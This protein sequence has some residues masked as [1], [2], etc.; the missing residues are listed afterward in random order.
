MLQLSRLPRNALKETF[1]DYAVLYSGATSSFI[2]PEN[3]AEPTGEKSTKI[4]KIPNGQSMKASEKAMLPNKKLRDK[5]RECDI[6]PGLR[7]DSLVSVGKLADAGYYTILMPGNQ[8]VQIFDGTKSKVYLPR[9]A[10]LRGWRDHQGLWRVPIKDEEFSLQK[11]ELDESLNNVFDLPY[12]EQTIRYLHACAGFP[13][14]RTWINAIK[15]GNYIGWPM[16][17][18]QNVNKYFPESTET[19]K[20]HMNHQCQGVRS[21]NRKPQEPEE[22]DSKSE[23]GKKER[24]VYTKVI[25]LLDKKGTIYTDQTGNLPVQSRSGNRFIMVMVAIDSNANL[26]IPVKDHTDQQL[27]SAYATLLKRV[28]M[29]VYR[30]RNIS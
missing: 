21:T 18:V 6:L 27:R 19:V 11:E 30:S 1:G 4:V 26:V 15:K 3:G 25:D 29:L 24:D 8:G 5:A 16:L 10:I 28:K 7:K 14:R 23:I 20:G 12:M 9:E 22:I 2:K 13:T 17:T